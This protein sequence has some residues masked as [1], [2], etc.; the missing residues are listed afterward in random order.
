MTTTSNSYLAMY[1]KMPCVSTTHGTWEVHEK[2][3][4]ATFKKLLV[5]NPLLDYDIY[6]TDRFLTHPNILDSNVTTILQ[7]KNCD[8]MALVEQDGGKRGIILVELKSGLSKN[9]LVDAYQQLVFSL[10]KA[11]QLLSLCDDFSV[12]T[13]SP[14]VI[15]AC[16]GAANSDKMTELKDFANKHYQAMKES[17]E[18][19]FFGMC[20]PS[21]LTSGECTLEVRKMPYLNTLPLHEN[22]RNCKVRLILVTAPDSTASETSID[23]SI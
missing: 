7:N 5:L 23:L 17:G 9:N 20:L 1:D 8:G 18:C 4:S 19:T 21:L 16:H 10:L 13:Y 6:D 11:T 14:I 22:I 2:S 3:P 12:T 15:I